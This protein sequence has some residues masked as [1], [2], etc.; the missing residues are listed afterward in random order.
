VAEISAGGVSDGFS[1]IQAKGEK[2]RTMFKRTISTLFHALVVVVA[3]AVA[4]GLTVTGHTLHVGGLLVAK[5]AVLG[6]VL[7]GFGLK[8]FGP[9]R[10]SIWAGPLS[11][12]RP[13]EAMIAESEDALSEAA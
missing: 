4:V 2:Q 8:G 7:F 10:V 1:K 13:P 3:T 9:D 5:G 11:A 12:V 6:A